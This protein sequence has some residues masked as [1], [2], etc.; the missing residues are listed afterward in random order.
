MSGL[1]RPSLVPKL[2]FGTRGKDPKTQKNTLP[3]RGKFGVRGS[4]A[5]ILLRMI[6]QRMFSPFMN[7]MCF[8]VMSVHPFRPSIS[9]LWAIGVTDN[10]GMWLLAFC[11]PCRSAL[12]C[13]VRGND[14]DKATS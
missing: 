12:A 3:A 2:S 6:A 7:L 4:V 5:F 14:F 8:S 13:F 11:K 9:D 10:H 1:F